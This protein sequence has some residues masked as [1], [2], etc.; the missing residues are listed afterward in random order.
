MAQRNSHCSFCGAAYAPDQPWPRTCAACANIAYRNPL[1]V[2]VLLLPV[3]GGLLTVRRGIPPRLGELALPGGYIDH[4]E[5]WQAGAVRE[6]REET[7]ISVDV[8][9]VRLFDVH[10]APD[11]TVLVFGLARPRRAGDLPAFTASAEAS[12]RVVI[13]APQPLAFP[14]H[15]RVAARWFA[16]PG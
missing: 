2:A 8:G 12:E 9:E 1:P 7:G 11:G 13:A 5:A 10:S 16:E 6:L 15:T 4:G 3:D 14:L